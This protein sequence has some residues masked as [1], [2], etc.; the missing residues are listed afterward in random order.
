MKI[1]LQ[2]GETMLIRGCGEP[3]RLSGRMPIRAAARPVPARRR[4]EPMLNA[5]AI[6]AARRNATL[7]RDEA[8]PPGR[9]MATDAESIY[10]ARR[11]A[12][13]QNHPAPAGNH[14]K[15]FALD[16]DTIYRNRLAAAGNR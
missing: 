4:P 6:Y 1:T 13:Q 8:T 5:S 9:T 14:G 3:M 11:L 10:R 7:V 2:N 15:G 12:C 16:A